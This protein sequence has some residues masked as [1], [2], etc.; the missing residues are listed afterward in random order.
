MSANAVPV[1]VDKGEEREAERDGGVRGGRVD[2]GEQS[3]AIAEQDEDE[4]AGENGQMGI[5]AVAHDLFSLI[6]DELMGHF[7]ELLG[8]AGLFDA[9]P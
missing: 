9:E 6:V 3:D 2:A 4:E 5:V 7:R 8:G 1:V